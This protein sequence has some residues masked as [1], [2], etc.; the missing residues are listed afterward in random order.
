MHNSKRFLSEKR[1]LAELPVTLRTF[2]SLGQNRNADT[3]IFSPL[4]VVGPCVT[5]GRY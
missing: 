5:I 1:P 2:G 3:R 4:A